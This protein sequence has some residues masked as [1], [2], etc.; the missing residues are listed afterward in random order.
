MSRYLRWG[1]TKQ[2]LKSENNMQFLFQL[3]KSCTCL[4]LPI[5]H[6]HTYTMVKYVY[7]YK[8]AFMSPTWFLYF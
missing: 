1:V 8:S 3:F 4:N 5:T 2:I 7:T 6:S